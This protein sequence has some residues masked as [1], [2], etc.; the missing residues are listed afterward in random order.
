MERA[1]VKTASVPARDEFEIII[2]F[3]G[4]IK[5]EPVD[6]SGFPV[7][8]PF[9]TVVFP[10]AKTPIFGTWM[11]QEQLN[12]VYSRAG[13]GKTGFMMELLKATRDGTSLLGQS[14]HAPYTKDILWVNG[15]LPPALAELQLKDLGP[16][17]A[18][19]MDMT[20]AATKRPYDLNKPE[21]WD[22]MMK[23]AK[24]YGIVVFDTRSSLF[25]GDHMDAMVAD[26][27]F[28]RLQS[29]A[30]FGVC[31]W[32]CMH[33]GKPVANAPQSAF[34]SS[35]SEWYVD[36]IVG[37]SRP[38]KTEWACKGNTSPDV[39]AALSELKAAGIARGA[40]LYVDHE[41]TKSGQAFP[42]K[43]AGWASTP[44]GGRKLVHALTD[45]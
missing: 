16:I 26:D 33:A 41:K 37:L 22:L 45:V 19:Y 43:A 17:G 24:D 10:P 20:D 6:V 5:A 38:N 14:G 27:L 23:T 35:A 40:A 36:N 18:D 1:W 12:V 21:V 34:G 13:V 32:L 44:T 25:K 9:S 3:E 7:P 11:A 8:K 42:T 4:P 29:L 31:V 2:G 30:R 15:D 39:K 28:T